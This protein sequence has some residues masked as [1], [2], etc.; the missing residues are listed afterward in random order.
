MLIQRQKCG[1]VNRGELR[2]DPNLVASQGNARKEVVLCY[3]SETSQAKLGK[4]FG[5]QPRARC[6]LK[7]KIRWRY[8]GEE[9]CAK[10]S[11]AR[12]KYDAR[13]DGL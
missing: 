12:A 1:A 10:V 9:W 2:A 7:S 13:L 4:R 8:P 6:R 5:W 11:D 3:V